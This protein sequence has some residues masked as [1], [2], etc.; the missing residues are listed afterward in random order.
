[1]WMKSTASFYG[2]PP[3]GWAKTVGQFPDAS[4]ENGIDIRHASGF[5]L[6]TNSINSLMID[7]RFGDSNKKRF[8]AGE[9]H[10]VDTGE[11]VTQSISSAAFGNTR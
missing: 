6:L 1:M 3:K 4:S 7:E 9:F 11:L 10:H 5:V 8:S 2:F